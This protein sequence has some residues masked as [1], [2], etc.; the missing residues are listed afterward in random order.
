MSERAS[1]NSVSLQLVATR[2]CNAW[3]R[4]LELNLLHTPSDLRLTCW[5]SRLSTSTVSPSWASWLSNPPDS[6]CIPFA[7]P[8]PGVFSSFKTV[9]PVT[10]N[11]TARASATILRKHRDASEVD[12]PSVRSFLCFRAELS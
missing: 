10:P 7:D 2:S 5:T 6:L 9:H 11:Q 12:S 4:Q 3:L 8:L 1:W